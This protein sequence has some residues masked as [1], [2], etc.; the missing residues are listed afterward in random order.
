MNS[1]KKKWRKSTKE[2]IK[3]I[4]R[5]NHDYEY[6]KR[7]DKRTEKQIINSILANAYL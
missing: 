4:K 2:I 6:F 3:E 7:M 1:A 5:E